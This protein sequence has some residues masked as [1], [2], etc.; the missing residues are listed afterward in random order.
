[1]KKKLITYKKNLLCKDIH[2]PLLMILYVNSYIKNNMMQFVSAHG[3]GLASDPDDPSCAK[4]AT[5]NIS[6][7]IPRPNPHA[8]RQSHVRFRPSRPTPADRG[9][10][11]G[12]A[13]GCDG[14][15]GDAW[16]FN[17]GGRAKLGI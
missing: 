14:R 10:A 4:G 7:A 11:A 5:L 6:G 13:G 1:M 16:L 15:G 17:V 8:Q 2:T 12:R 9:P 3:I